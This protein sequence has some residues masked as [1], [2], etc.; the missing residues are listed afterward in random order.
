MFVNVGVVG[1]DDV[2]VFFF[3]YGYDVFVYF[4]EL[5]FFVIVV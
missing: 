5:I 1:K 4:N 3:E 2:Y